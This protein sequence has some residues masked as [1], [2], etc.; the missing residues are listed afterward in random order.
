MVAASLLKD[1]KTLS[2]LER[3][4]EALKETLMLYSLGQQFI[5]L[6]FEVD[7]RHLLLDQ[8]SDADSS[9]G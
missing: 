3:Q 5:W 4:F 2:T 7:E 8:P 6:V 1:K 9:E